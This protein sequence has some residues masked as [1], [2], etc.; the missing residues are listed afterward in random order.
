MGV[1]IK[2]ETDMMEGD[3]V[4]IH[5]DR[6]ATEVNRATL[7]PENNSDGNCLSMSFIEV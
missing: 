6:A 4:V 5:I 7:D 1:R 2:E 3:V